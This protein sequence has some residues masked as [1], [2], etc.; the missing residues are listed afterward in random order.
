MRYACLLLIAMTIGCSGNP[1]TLTSQAVTGKLTLRGEPIG[2]VLLTL[3]P[4]EN[5][6]TA[7]LPVAK[8]GSFSAEIVPG[9]YAFFVGKLSG[10][11]SDTVLKK[12]E[13]K[14]YEADLT[15]TINVS[16]GSDLT[17]NI[18]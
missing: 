8:D 17:I 14:Y 7:P 12:I 5:G 1:P 13:P 3:Q 11:N 9:K 15:R 18:E 6:H 4:L 2:D 10:K 16:P